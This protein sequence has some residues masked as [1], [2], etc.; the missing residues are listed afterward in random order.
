MGQPIHL[1]TYQANKLLFYSFD[2]L[3]NEPAGPSEWTVLS[4][5]FRIYTKIL[6]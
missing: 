4:K 6:E 2:N 3:S 5:W 1:T